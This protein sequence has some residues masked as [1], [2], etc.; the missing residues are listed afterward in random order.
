MEPEILVRLAEHTDIPEL[1]RLRLAYFDEEFGVLPQ[2]QLAAIS[3]QL[4]QYFAAHL[5]ADC[6]AVAAVLPDGHL[7]ACA[8]LTV[9]ENP[10][11]PS[12]PNGRS[13]Y[14]LGVFTEPQH[15]GKGLATRVMRQLLEEAKQ[16]RLDTVRLSASDMGKGIYERLGFAVRQTHFTEMEW[17]PA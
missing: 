17:F 11:N 6:I 9:S 16:L 10:A 3:A 14:V 4:P 2:E 13:G 7:A 5:G 1:I 8:L 15:R 12:F